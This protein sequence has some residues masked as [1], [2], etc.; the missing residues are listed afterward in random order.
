MRRADPLT[1]SPGRSCCSWGRWSRAWRRL[2]GGRG[3]GRWVPVVIVGLYF[4]YQHVIE[5]IEALRTGNMLLDVLVAP[6]TWAGVIFGYVFCVY[7]LEAA[8]L[9]HLASDLLAPVT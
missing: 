2:K 6:Q 4:G 1:G 8:V 3:G 9:T 5:N 7:G